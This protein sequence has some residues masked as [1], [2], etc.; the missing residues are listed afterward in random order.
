[1][2]YICSMKRKKTFS[3]I[4][5]GMLLGTITG[6]LLGFL[7]VHFD[8]V[9][10]VIACGILLLAG[11]APGIQETQNNRAYRRRVKWHR[12]RYKDSIPSIKA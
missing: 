6:T 12:E 5:T 3:E 11:I 8:V 7:I 9:F 2:L 4:I 10:T 1:M